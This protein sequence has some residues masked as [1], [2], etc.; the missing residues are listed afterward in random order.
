MVF[1]D[2]RRGIVA[3]LHAATI[4]L[5]KRRIQPGL[6]SVTVLPLDCPSR[7]L[8]L[9]ERVVFRQPPNFWR[10]P[11]YGVTFL[12]AQST[13]PGMSGLTDSDFPDTASRTRHGCQCPRLGVCYNTNHISL[14]PCQGEDIWSR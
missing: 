9:R 13:G 14:R 4:L 8:Q 7:W 3:S 10:T 6:P 11:L 1:E 12:L 2:R 5:W